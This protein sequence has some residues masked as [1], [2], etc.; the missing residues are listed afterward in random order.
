MGERDRRHGRRK[1]MKGSRA[2]CSS[3]RLDLF[4]VDTPQFN[5]HG[6]QKQTTA[7]GVCISTLVVTVMLLFGCVKLL[8]LVNRHN[9][10]IVV[11]ESVDALTDEFRVSLS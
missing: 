11:T 2:S 4:G 3:R 10:N 8:K 9:P 6:A 5:V 1:P 7:C